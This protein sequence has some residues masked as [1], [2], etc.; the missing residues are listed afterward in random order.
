MV[1]T[2]FFKKKS[3][4]RLLLKLVYL[5]KLNNWSRIN[6]IRFHVRLF[7]PIFNFWQIF[8]VWFGT[9]A[10]SIYNRN[11]IVDPSIHKTQNKTKF[12]FQQATVRIKNNCWKLIRWQFPCIGNEEISKSN[13]TLCE[14][15]VERAAILLPLFW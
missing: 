10:E 5:C 15:R 8:H 1:N 13:K 4:I 6:Q 11:I 9:F 12:S 14:I 3:F 2:I 7:I